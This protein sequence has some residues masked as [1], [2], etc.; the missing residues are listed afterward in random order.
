MI[1][2]RSRQT[3][4]LPLIGAHTGAGACL[5]AL[6]VWAFAGAGPRAPRA[7]AASS[8]LATTR[9]YVEADYRLIHSAVG[10]IPKGEAVLRD[11]LR[12]VRADCPGAAGGSP[13]DAMSTQLS[14]EVIGTMVLAVVD[15]GAPV[16]KRFIRAAEGLRW[17]SGALTRRV[18]AYVAHVRTLTALP[19]P[20]LCSDVRAWAASGFQ[21]LPTSTEDFNRRFMPAWVAAGELPSALS[22]YEQGSTRAL[23][24]RASALES[25]F[26]EFEARAVETWGTIMEALE[27]WP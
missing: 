5:L 24:K 11:V 13:Q 14:N 9:S 6:A 17:S 16:A 1:T 20:D 21:R 10:E 18:E 8:D 12:R 4:P 2:G 19:A 15:A 27:L 22:R 3:G 23:A 7:L 26:S 25:T